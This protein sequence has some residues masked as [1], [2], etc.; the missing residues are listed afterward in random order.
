M[1]TAVLV[2]SL[3]VAGCV[4]NTEAKIVVNATTQDHKCLAEA[5][6]YEAGNEPT[7]GRRAVAHVVVNRSKNARYPNSICGVVHQRNAMGRGCQ[8]TWVC[9]KHNP[10][11]GVAW[12]EAQEIATLVLTGKSW[13]TS[14]G[15]LAFNGT[16]DK[17]GWSKKHYKKTAQI[18]GHTFWGPVGQNKIAVNR[19]GELK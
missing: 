8:F 16:K 3:A 17:I 4:A 10:P 12:E 2:S 18:G 15:A 6:Y 13:D 9:R 5:I 1:K 7:H 11:K 14:Y 19:L